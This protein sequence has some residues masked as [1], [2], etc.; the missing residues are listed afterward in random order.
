VSSTAGTAKNT[1]LDSI[2]ALIKEIADFNNNVYKGYRRR[3]T[4]GKAVLL[5]LLEDVPAQES[6]EEDRHNISINMLVRMRADIQA[7]AEAEMS[8]FI[9]LIGKVEDKIKANTYKAGTW[10]NLRISRITY[11]FGQGET[12][13]LYNALIRLEVQAQW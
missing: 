11:T 12:F 2:V 5:H 9:E 1:I 10:E 8:E 7:D 3:L 13:V 4:S 6:T